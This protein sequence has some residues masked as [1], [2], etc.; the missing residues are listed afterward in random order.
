MNDSGL[1]IAS[2]AFSVA[3]RTTARRANGIPEGIVYKLQRIL[4]A[5]NSKID[6]L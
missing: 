3:P 1:S 2:F 5:A 6:Q 4:V